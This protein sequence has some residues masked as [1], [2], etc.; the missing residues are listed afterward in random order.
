[1][2]CVVNSEGLNGRGIG[3]VG[4]Q[5]GCFPSLQQKW[6][7][8]LQQNWLARCSLTSCVPPCPA[9]PVGV[10]IS[11]DHRSAL[12]AEIKVIN[13]QQRTFIRV[14]QLGG[15][16]AAKSRVV[17]NVVYVVPRWER[18]L[19]GELG[20]EVRVEHHTGA[21]ALLSEHFFHGQCSWHRHVCV[22][23]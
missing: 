17:L 8:G 16:I 21:S 5:A 20:S 6:V 1:M 2:Q 15:Q 7:H 19:S 3:P 12:G 22:C 13:L 11:G 14:P 4:P 18:Q 10:D 23:I 9:C